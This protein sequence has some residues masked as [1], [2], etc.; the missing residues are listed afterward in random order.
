[1]LYRS[2]KF[3]NYIPGVTHLHMASTL[4]NVHRSKFISLQ[5]EIRTGTDEIKLSFHS[6]IKVLQKEGEIK[7]FCVN[8]TL[9]IS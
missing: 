8:G 1:M 6:E 4:L 7:G 9:P 3:V 2:Q 5:E